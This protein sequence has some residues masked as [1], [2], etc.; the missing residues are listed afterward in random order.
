MPSPTTK[1]KLEALLKRREKRVVSLKETLKN[2][3]ADVDN[4]EFQL[5]R[6]EK[7]VIAAAKL[8]K[9][10]EAAAAKKK[11]EDEAKEAAAE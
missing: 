11:A 1:S 7:A 8:A 2:A 4:T 6:L 10:K 5:Y 3:K 9:K